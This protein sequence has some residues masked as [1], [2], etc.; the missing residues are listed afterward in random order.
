MC[1]FPASGSSWESLARGGVD[2]THREKE[3]KLIALACSKPPKG[4]ARW[5]L[6]FGE[7]G[8]SARHCR[9]CQRQHDRARAQKKHSS[10]HRRQHWVIAPKTNSA[11]VAVME[12]V[13]AVYTR[14]RDGDCTLIHDFVR[15]GGLISYRKVT[16]TIDEFEFCYA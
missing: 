12:D 13:L 6:R 14:S 4:R 15:A 2:D 10:A 1:R 9:S 11:F 8:R 7:Q 3:A 5:T 16:F